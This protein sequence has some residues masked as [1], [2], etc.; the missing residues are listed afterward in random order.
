[1][2]CLS[3]GTRTID[4]TLT[5]KPKYKKAWL[6]AISWCHSTLH[7]LFW[8]K[9]L[10]ILLLLLHSSFYGDS[11][12]MG[13]W[14]SLL[15]TVKRWKPVWFG[16]VTS[17]NSLSKTILQGTLEDGWHHCRQRKCWVDN[18][19]ECTSLPMPE[20][21]TR[22]SCRKDWERISA[23]S[24]LMSPRWPNLSRDWTPIV[25]ESNCVY[26]CFQGLT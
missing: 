26:D 12:L 18:I 11:T 21:L 1:M 3:W 22:A 14:E 7:P 23:E 9:S 10:K 24:T 16:H 20:L 8:T 13:P 5:S 6:F 19:K 4:G 15:A 25:R 17:Y 2:V